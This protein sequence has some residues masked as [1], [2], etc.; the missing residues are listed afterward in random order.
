MNARPADLE[1]LARERRVVLKDTPEARV[2]RLGDGEHAVVR[3]TYQNRGMRWL[4]S[5]WRQ[6]RA[7][8]EH[9]RLAAIAAAG[10]PCL[11]P[12]A[13]SEQR[14]FGG[15]T[16]STL[17][18]RWLPDAVALKQVLRDLHPAAFRARSTLA[19]AMGALVGAMHHAG[20]LWNTPM[21]RNALVVGDPAQA[22]LVVC[23]PPSCL[24]LGRDLH[25]KR[26]ARIDLFLGA[27]SP[28][29]RTDWSR[30]ERLRWLLGYTAGDR[31][32]ARGLWRRL[33]H[34]RS[35]QNV[36]ERAL[37]TAAFTYIVGPRRARQ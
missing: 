25:G 27:F 2:E 17:V 32:A 26:L 20:F 14:R 30:S 24:V 35:L 10:V 4:Q 37:A 16:S 1:R 28:S 31:D 8:R 19:T 23:D 11:Q 15:V 33:V 5:L 29:R 36:V 22:R 34:R 13:W 9:D 18:T 21:P 3:K 6:S 12:L 7:H